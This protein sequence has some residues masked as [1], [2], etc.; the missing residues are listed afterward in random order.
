MNYKEKFKS[1]VRNTHT[2]AH[3]ESDHRNTYIR[4]H[5]HGC[6]TCAREW[7]LQRQV[8]SRSCVCERKRVCRLKVYNN[9][10]I[11]RQLTPLTFVVTVAVA[12]SQSHHHHLATPI[13]TRLYRK[14]RYLPTR[15][16]TFSA[17]SSCASL[18]NINTHVS[19]LACWIP[20][21][22]P[23]GTGLSPKRHSGWRPI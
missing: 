19:V 10:I 20:C 2:Y 17:R 9:T 22:S 16:A 6:T 4:T 7:K 14:C 1:T 18:A 5:I 15:N 3:I 11:T 21:C 12:G 13:A 8:K 23:G